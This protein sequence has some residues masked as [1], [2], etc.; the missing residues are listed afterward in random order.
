MSIIAR[1][2][3]SMASTR[4]GFDGHGHVGA[5]AGQ[6]EILVAQA[7]GFADHQ[8]EPAAGHAHHAVPDQAHRGEGQ[9]QFAAGAA[10]R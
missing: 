8:E 4:P 2:A 6:A 3:Q 9:F 1:M 5:E 10:T 7:E